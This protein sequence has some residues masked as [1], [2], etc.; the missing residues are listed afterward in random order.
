MLKNTSKNID[1]ITSCL[2]FGYQLWRDGSFGSEAEGIYRS[3]SGVTLPVF[4]LAAMR[5]Q[6][7]VNNDQKWGEFF[8]FLMDNWKE[9]A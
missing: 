8:T 4:G 7:W 5:V 9:E 6:R 3:L 1:T 2:K